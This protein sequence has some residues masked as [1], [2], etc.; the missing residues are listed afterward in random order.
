[1]LAPAGFALAEFLFS[2]IKVTLDSA[3]TCVWCALECLK[4]SGTPPGA[5]LILASAS[6]RD[7]LFR[8]G[9]LTIAVALASTHTA[10]SPMAFAILLRTGATDASV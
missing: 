5:P 3:A 7:I 4:K 6:S 2:R 1:L 8:S 10:A 9:G